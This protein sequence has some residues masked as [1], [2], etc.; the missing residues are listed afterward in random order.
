VRS[1]PGPRRERGEEPGM[2]RP[3]RSE[4]TRLWRVLC[5]RNGHKCS[6]SETW[7]DEAG[8]R[9]H[10]SPLGYVGEFCRT[11]RRHRSHGLFHR[12]RTRA[13]RDAR[14]FSALE[15]PM[16]HPLALGDKHTA[17]APRAGPG[18]HARSRGA[19]NDPPGRC[20]LVPPV[21]LKPSPRQ[22]R[23][24]TSLGEAGRTITP[25]SSKEE[26]DDGRGH[27]SGRAL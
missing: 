7:L 16:A 26:R 6:A 21:L 25:P 19:S 4:P 14:R 5:R 15:P 22:A 11:V 3:V 8:S 13:E 18:T 9:R 23:T 24:L 17:P 12:P 2:V 27:H 20:S 10:V 1:C